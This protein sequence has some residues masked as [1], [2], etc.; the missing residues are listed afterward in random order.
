VTRS[1]GWYRD[2]DGSGELRYWNGEAW[3][4]EHPPAEE[5]PRPKK[6][7]QEWAVLIGLGTAIIVLIGGI[8]AAVILAMKMGLGEPTVT[9][10][11]TSAHASV[12]LETALETTAIEPTALQDTGPKEPEAAVGEEVHDGDFSFV[13]TGVD[14]LDA[15]T[16]PE[17][18][19]I[20]KTAQGEFVIVRMTV[21]NVGADPQKFFVSFD[22]LSDGTSVFKS[23]DE[24]WLYLGNSVNDVNPG[25]TLD[26]AVVFDVP[27]DTEVSSIELHDGPS[28]KG[29]TVGL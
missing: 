13:V 27:K 20:E 15:V 8:V 10:Q 14:R 7:G 5:P 28:S 22:T 26:T 18:P 19:E 1:A 23:D 17:H 3:A 16:H 4:D 11:T 12:P 25:D 24:A 29:V 9:A 2:S 21:T 6:S